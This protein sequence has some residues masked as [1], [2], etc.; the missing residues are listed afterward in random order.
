MHC[1]QTHRVLPH[2]IQTN[3]QRKSLFSSDFAP[4]LNAQPAVLAFDFLWLSPIKL[5]ICKAISFPAD[6]L[7]QHTAVTLA[8]HILLRELLPG[9]AKRRTLWLCGPPVAIWIP[10]S[11]YVVVSG[12]C[13]QITPVPDVIHMLPWVLVFT[14]A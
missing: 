13:D 3:R 10:R 8:A 1:C 5:P 12:R 11:Y 9:G 14:D 4:A 7:S 6:E 2:T